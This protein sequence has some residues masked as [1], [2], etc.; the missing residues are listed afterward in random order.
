MG[1]IVLKDHVTIN[2]FADKQHTEKILKDI[3]KTIKKKMLLL[4]S[5]RFMPKN[6]NLQA[7]VQ[8]KRVLDILQR[9]TILQHL[10]SRL[11]HQQHFF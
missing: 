6:F 10:Q 9:R 7:R 5:V 1:E 8:A 11:E 3:E 2:Y 4:Y